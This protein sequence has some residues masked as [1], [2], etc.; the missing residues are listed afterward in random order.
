MVAF[1]ERDFRDSHIVDIEFQPDFNVPAFI[2]AVNTG[3]FTAFDGT[4]ADT[5]SAGYVFRGAP[6][7]ADALEPRRDRFVAVRVPRDRTSHEAADTLRAALGD[8]AVAVVPRP[9]YIPA[10]T[11]PCDELIGASDQ[12]PTNGPVTQWYLHRC[13]ATMAWSHNFGGGVVVANIDWGFLLGHDD[14]AGRYDAS[15]LHNST[16][17]SSDV[18]RGSLHHG[19]GAAGMIGAGANAKGIAGFAPE[20]TL[21]LIQADEE[22]TALRRA[23]TERLLDLF[24][25]WASG[26]DWVVGKTSTL[27]K[28]INVEIQTGRLHSPESSLPI[29][30]AVRRA[31]A[32][33]AFVCV[34]A[35]NGNLPADVDECGHTIPDTG[36]ITIAA[37][38]YDDQENRR[39]FFSNYGSRIC[40]SAPGDPGLDL[41]CGAASVSAYTPRYGGTSGASAKVA[42]ALAL[43]LSR[44]P[45]LKH[46]DLLNAIAKL[47]K[48][49]DGPDEIGKFLDCVALSDAAAA[50]HAK[51]TAAP[52]PLRRISRLARRRP[53]R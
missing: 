34:P 36:S 39:A 3:I 47:P 49:T 33:N 20:C 32:A 29:R 11:Y 52:Q 4:A 38:G 41:T 13:R 15:G 12:Q 18:E 1:S 22:Q 16:D 6:A 50:E 2:E 9:I 25:P 23:A 42:G 21:W 19:T 10:T 28:V 7:L 51:S 17:G 30:A 40:L 35:G 27:P 24:D 43:V 44:T 37:T 53:K 31:V 8:A 48:K 46:A 14:L 26:I 45:K 5:Y